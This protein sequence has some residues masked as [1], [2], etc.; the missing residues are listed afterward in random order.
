MQLIDVLKKCA[1]MSPSI[2]EYGLIS[3]LNKINNKELYEH[4]KVCIETLPMQVFITGD[5]SDNNLKCY[6]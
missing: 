2:Y 1:E 4:Y 3:D 6:G 5:S